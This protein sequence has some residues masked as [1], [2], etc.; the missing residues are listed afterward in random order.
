MVLPVVFAASAGQPIA[1]AEV[2]QRLAG[3]ACLGLLAAFSQRGETKQSAGNATRDGGLLTTGRWIRSLIGPQPVSEFVDLDHLGDEFQL[4]D[5]LS[6][7]SGDLGAVTET[8][9][10]VATHSEA[11]SELGDQDA[12]LSFDRRPS[13]ESDA[14]ALIRRLQER[15]VF[16]QEQVALIETELRTAIGSHFGVQV[17]SPLS[18]GVRVGRFIVDVPLGRGGEAS[19]YRG[20]DDVGEPAAIKILQNIHVS[21]RFRREM[22]V[23]RQLAHPNIVTAYEVGDFRGLP[24]IAMELLRGPDLH[25]LV[26]DSGP[27]G[28]QTSARYMLQ[29]SRALEHAHK[30][31]LIHR[32]IKPANLILNGQDLIKLADMGLAS[33]VGHDAS[34]DSVGG[35][36]TKHGHLAGTLPYMAPEQARSLADATV[37]SDIYGLGATWFY[38]LTGRERLPGE[39]FSE[40]FQNLLIERRFEELP[41]D[42]LPDSLRNVYERMLAYDVKARYPNCAELADDLERALIGCGESSVGVAGINVLVV[43]DSQTDMLLAIKMLKRLNSTLSIHQA[44]TLACGLEICGHLPINLA[45]LDLSLPDSSGVATVSRFRET[46]P[47]LPL[48]VLTGMSQD[49]VGSACLQAGADTFISKSSL[50]P[51]RMERMIFVTLSRCGLRSHP[52]NRRLDPEQSP[53]KSERSSRRTSA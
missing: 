13:C 17:G 28:W 43:E 53:K 18:A 10:E 4:E 34:I 15:Q 35:F 16:T 52:P 7:E 2:A 38:L 1:V 14:T 45:L 49:E 47:Q 3:L 32:D 20:H 26:R 50:T 22:H 11:P 5:L 8:A 21:D 9:I 19:V 48:V 39:T 44:R 42:L 27:L 23:V 25:V 36:K 33:M 29:A 37:Q 31:D 41:H 12:D 30:R 51:H 24:F 46:M 40:Q 6:D